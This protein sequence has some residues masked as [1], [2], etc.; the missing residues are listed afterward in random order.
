MFQLKHGRDLRATR[1]MGKDESSVLFRHNINYRL[2]SSKIK[3]KKL[4]N[5]NNFTILQQGE[6]SRFLVFTGCLYLPNLQVSSIQ[7]SDN[8]QR[9]TK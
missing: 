8:F 6:V 4:T 3:Q 9:M 1:A 7:L 5:Y 2:A